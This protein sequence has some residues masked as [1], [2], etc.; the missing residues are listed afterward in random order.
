MSFADFY[1]S[2]RGHPPVQEDP[3]ETPMT[4]APEATATPHPRLL[5]RQSDDKGL[6]TRPTC[7][8]KTRGFLSPKGCHVHV[9]QRPAFG[10]KAET[11][12]T[13]RPTFCDPG[14]VTFGLHKENRLMKLDH[15]RSPLTRTATTRGAITA[16]QRAKCRRSR[17]A[18]H[19]EK[20]AVNA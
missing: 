3:E 5:D 15:H 1:A 7:G 12:P 11:R 6:M 9:G 13:E 18:I 17:A 20:G 16:D 19:K 2:M 14:A 8:L 10:T 4:T